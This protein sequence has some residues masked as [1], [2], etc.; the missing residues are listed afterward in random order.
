MSR[1]DWLLIFFGLKGSP[2]GIDPVRIQ[3]GMFLFAMEGGVSDD[4][5]YD[6]RPYNY[7]PM[8]SQIYSDVEALEAEGLI[9]SANVPGHTWKRYRVT[10]LGVTRA[11]ALRDGLLDRTAVHRLYEIK[12]SVMAR[13]FN[14]LLSDVYDRYPNYASRS[15][16]KRS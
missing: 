5:T 9:A 10:E 14:A 4:E 7:G 11:R 2:H 8:A 13:T 16:F 3:K 6:F 15:V 1:R 12:Q